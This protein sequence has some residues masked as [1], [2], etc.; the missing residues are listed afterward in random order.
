MIDQPTSNPAP[1]QPF[2]KNSQ[3]LSLLSGNTSLFF[4]Y[5]ATMLVRAMLTWEITGDEM[6]LAYINLASAVCIV[7]MSLIAGAATDRFE[8]RTLIIVAHGVMLVAEG[9]GLLLYVTGQLQYHHLVVITI[10]MSMSFAF[11]TP[12]RTAIMADALGKSRLQKGIAALSSGSS[13]ARMLSPAIAGVLA[14]VYGIAV[15]YGFLV[16]LYAIATL[17]AITLKPSR[18][19]NPGTAH[20]LE[21]IRQ[22]FVYLLANRP[23]AMCLIFGFL[24]S[25]VVIPLQNLLVIFADEVWDAGS[26]GLGIL[27]TSLGVGSLLGSAL[28]M[29]FTPSS[30]VRVLLI[31]VLS[32]AVFIVL[33][34]QSPY[35]WIACPFLL[36]VSS[37]SVF[38]QATVQTA[39]QMMCDG[40]MRGRV[41]TFNM[42]G[43]GLS[44]AF[45]VPI[46]FMAKQFGVPLAIT[47]TG[48]VI[49]IL[50]FSV[51]YFSPSFREIDAAVEHGLPVTSK[52]GPVENQARA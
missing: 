27:L 43:I 25:A 14:D 41:V 39:T 51:W 31:S 44:P 12:A 34:S 23:L 3:F 20:F 18:S 16:C 5:A 29:R 1:E 42:I 52:K 35:F 13:L 47:I 2:W 11:T 19:A 17:S 40:S 50:A 10:A 45:T 33:F 21:D 49:G 8:R 7:S 4:G 28:L 46:A 30:V 37:A 6:L 38:V 24:P 22:G 32:L 48:T 26:S 9:G 36:A 15:A